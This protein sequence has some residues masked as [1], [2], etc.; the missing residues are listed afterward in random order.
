VQNA[1]GQ[2][3]AMM[4]DS[5]DQAGRDDFLIE[6]RKRIEN[7]DHR[8]FIALLLVVPH[9]RAILEIMR[10]HYKQDAFFLLAQ[11]VDELCAGTDAPLVALDESTRLVIKL[12]IQDPSLD[13]LLRRLRSE[14]PPDVVE[15][16]DLAL[17]R[18]YDKLRTT[19]YFWPL[20]Q[21]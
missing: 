4:L 12:L 6:T 10:H 13:A 1:H 7:P 11:W 16:Q 15:S 14:L 3:G 5:I 17:R 8:L 2:R 9:R 18:L 19:S 21:S 20:F